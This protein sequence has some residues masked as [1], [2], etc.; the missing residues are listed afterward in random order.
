MYLP[1]VQLKISR[2]FYYNFHV[3]VSW[4]NRH[5]NDV[6]CHQRWVVASLVLSSFSLLMLPF[7]DFKTFDPHDQS[8]PCFSGNEGI[9]C[10]ILSVFMIKAASLAS[11]SAE[12]WC[13]KSTVMAFRIV[14]RD[15]IF[16]YFS[17]SS[18]RFVLV[19][20]FVFRIAMC[21]NPPMMK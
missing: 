10:V 15:R 6:H 5:F 21:I 4:A 9:V 11:I 18:D 19:S 17:K 3:H 7:I 1:S 14:N 12:D 20:F 13:T 2:Q 8:F 16:D